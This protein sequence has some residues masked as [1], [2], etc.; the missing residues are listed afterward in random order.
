MTIRRHTLT[1]NGT[2]LAR[3]FRV[4]ALAM[5]AYLGGLAVPSFG[6]GTFTVGVTVQT[7]LTE[8]IV[9]TITGPDSCSPGTT[10]SDDLTWAPLLDF[11]HNPVSLQKTNGK[12]IPA[13]WVY[14]DYIQNLYADLTPTSAFTV[15]LTAAG[16][17]ISAGAGAGTV[18][19]LP[20]VGTGYATTAETLDLN[21]GE[22]NNTTVWTLTDGSCAEQFSDTTSGVL[23]IT[24]IPSTPQSGLA[25]FNPFGCVADP[26]LCAAPLSA[27]PSALNPTTILASPQ[28]TSLATDGQS[29]VVLSF[30]SGAPDPVT[31]SVAATG[32]VGGAPIGSLSKFDP[33]Y[34]N[35]PSLSA[36]RTLTLPDIA[37]TTSD[38]GWKLYVLCDPLGARRH[39]H[40]SSSRHDR[41]GSTAN[42]HGHPGRFACRRSFDPGAASFASGSRNLELAEDLAA[43]GRVACLEL[44]TADR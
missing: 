41:L 15:Q 37:Y 10:T 17:V 1:A 19:I 44:S 26:L 21:T 33:N 42:G 6:Q 16:T 8:H 43:N 28:A 30:T 40:Q 24:L 2:F 5:A 25:A 20:L 3:P 7:Q 9:Q 14:S 31:F 32:A 27:V 36:N 4:L 12:W 18:D 38:N 35:G 23:Q 13:S 39:A 29:A 11:Q 34:L 22:F